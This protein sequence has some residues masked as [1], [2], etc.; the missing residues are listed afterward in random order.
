M[1]IVT[2]L[3]LIVV[4]LSLTCSARAQYDPTFSHYFQMESAY[5]AAAVGKDD[6]LNI[7]ADYNMGLAS[8]EGNP[9]TMYASVDAPFYF[10]KARQGAGFQF[11]ND[12]IG[13]FTHQR[14]ELQY[15]A[16][17][18]LLGGELSIGAQLG[19]LNE[20]YD[21]DEVD[22]EDSSDPAFATSDQT[23]YGL[24]LGA[25]LYYR[26]KAFYVG[27]SALHLS[28]PTIA[29]GEYN[30]LSI[31]RTYYF[32]AGYNIRLRN[33]F[34]T[35]KPSLFFRTDMTNYR[36]DVTCRLVYTVDGKTMYAGLGAS[37]TS[38]TLYVG[39]HFHGVLLGYSY[40]YYTSGLSLQDGSHELFIGY[41]MDLN[42]AKRGKNLHKS[43]RIL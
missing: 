1:K 31:A 3:L 5:N 30:E 37:N 4:A 23:G 41:Q 21:A 9:K 42:M 36:G 34:L 39:G 33:P 17:I 35:I 25:A 18:N 22:L 43:I 8:F 24:D 2:R 38:A 40:E 20:G 10:L 29:L 28:A 14:L 15:A 19:L 32:T 12:Q 26:R 11:V 6:Q 13:V 27:L 16:K 7:I